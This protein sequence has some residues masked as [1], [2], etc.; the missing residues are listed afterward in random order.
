MFITPKAWSRKTT[1]VA[2][3]VSNV[4]IE[5]CVTEAVSK[6]VLKNVYWNVS[7]VQIINQTVEGIIFLFRV[8]CT[9]NLL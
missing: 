8:Q 4:L 7:T 2:Q 1:K 9:L 6:C 3:V 5:M